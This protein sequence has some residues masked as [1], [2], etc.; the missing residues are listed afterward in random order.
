MK[1]LVLSDFH[2]EFEPLCIPD[3]GADVVILAG[4]DTPIIDGYC[5]LFKVSGSFNQNTRFVDLFG[6]GR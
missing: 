2:L 1:L 5:L 4:D 6:C 3:T